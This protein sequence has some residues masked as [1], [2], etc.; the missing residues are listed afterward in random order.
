MISFKA[1]K[2]SNDIYSISVSV[3]FI[4]EKDLANCVH[5]FFSFGQVKE[6]LLKAL[7]LPSTML[8]L[9]GFWLLCQIFPSIFLLKLYYEITLNYA[10]RDTFI[11]HNKT[12]YI[13]AVVLSTQLWSQ[14]VSERRI[15]ISQSA[16][17]VLIWEAM[18]ILA[19]SRKLMPEL[20]SLFLCFSNKNTDSV[21]FIWIFLFKQVST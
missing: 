1:M 21:G 11:S 19:T 4:S 18:H 8:L 20:R 14:Q 10:L 3:T 9:Q 7:I 16:Y 17:S 15:I 2:V 6:F 13:K 12:Q 5:L